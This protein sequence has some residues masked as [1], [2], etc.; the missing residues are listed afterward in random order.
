MQQRRRIKQA[1]PL[2]ERLALWATATR[3]LADNLPAGRKRDE[4]L[5][6]ARQADAAGHLDDWTRSRGSP[7]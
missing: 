3:K 7:K 4:L 1:V 6:K 5:K 2:K